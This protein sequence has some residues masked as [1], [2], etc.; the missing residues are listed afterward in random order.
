MRQWSKKELKSVKLAM[1]NSFLEE[2]YHVAEVQIKVCKEQMKIKKKVK[3]FHFL[4][5]GILIAYLVYFVNEWG[6][7]LGYIG[8]EWLILFVIIC[9]TS[10]LIWKSIYHFLINYYIKDEFIIEIIQQSSE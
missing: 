8:D 1:M 10:I 5:S 7:R 6:S 9:T 2:V 4:L 3:F